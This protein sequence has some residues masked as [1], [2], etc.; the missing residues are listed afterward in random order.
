LKLVSQVSSTDTEDNAQIVQGLSAFLL[1]LAMLYSNDQANETPPLLFSVE[2]LKDTIKKRIGLEEFSEKLEYISQHDF[3]SRTL[4]QRTSFSSTLFTLNNSSSKPKHQSSSSLLFDYEF[5]R[6]FKSNETLINNFLLNNNDLVSN[7]KQAEYK[8]TI[9]SQQ[10][11]LNEQ[12]LLN[13]K[14]EY[15][16][17]QLQEYC[18][19]LIQQEQHQIKV[20]ASQQEAIGVT[21]AIAKEKLQMQ[22]RIN[23]LEVKCNLLEEK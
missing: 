3:F 10:I 13:Q 21:A 8:K 5:T 20:N 22:A 14:L 1:G 7:E 11:N 9:N 4:K 12:I 16:L 19:Q 15:N 6:L 17:R 2:E 18:T 23:E